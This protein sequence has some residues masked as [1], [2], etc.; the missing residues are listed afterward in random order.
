MSTNAHPV[1]AIVPLYQKMK[2]LVITFFTVSA[3]T[4]SLGYQ[5]L[6]TSTVS[7]LVKSFDNLLHSMEDKFLH[8]GEF[9]VLFGNS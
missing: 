3:A 9:D 1:Q 2:A 4:L 8:R 6:L 5:Q 7:L